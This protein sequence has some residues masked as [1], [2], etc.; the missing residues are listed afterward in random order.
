MLGTGVFVNSAHEIVRRTTEG[1]LSV[2]TPRT[3]A[4]CGEFPSSRAVEANG[5]T[6]S[7]ATG[8][9]ALMAISLDGK[10][11][12]DSRKYLIKMV[13]RAENTGQELEAAPPNAP[14]KMHLKSWG[15]A[16]VLTFGRA[17]D[18]PTKIKKGSIEV[19][20]VGMIDGTWELFVENGKAHLACDTP[21]IK[22]AVFGRLVTT[23]G[24]GITTVTIPAVS[25]RNT[26]SVKPKIHRAFVSRKLKHGRKFRRS[27]SE[28]DEAP[29]RRSR[30]HSRRRRR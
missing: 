28:D 9:G 12:S 11:L 10:P 3:I 4:L 25:A 21:G 15:K 13:S 2:T 26:A 7:T 14:G 23:M 17:C 29:R 27:R 5:W 1:I 22:A 30:T 8:I 18:V 16:P 24:G 19:I 6:V 20:S